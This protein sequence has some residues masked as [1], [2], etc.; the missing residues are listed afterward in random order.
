MVV[1]SNM[2]YDTGFMSLNG[3]RFFETNAFLLCKYDIERVPYIVYNEEGTIYTTKNKGFIKQQTIGDLLRHAAY[4][5]AGLQ[6]PFDKLDKTVKRRASLDMIKQG[7]IDKIRS[8][9]NASDF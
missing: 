3:A 7:A 4:K 9:Y 8:E 2:P 6:A 5:N 1:T